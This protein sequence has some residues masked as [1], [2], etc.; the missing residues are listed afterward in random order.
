VEALEAAGATKGA[1]DLM[2]REQRNAINPNAKQ[3]STHMLNHSI[4][5]I[6]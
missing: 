4:R 6:E 1:E 2:W 3:T 5:A